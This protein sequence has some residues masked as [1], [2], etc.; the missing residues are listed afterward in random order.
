MN[1]YKEALGGEII[2]I[3]RYGVAPMP[4]DEDYK[5]KIMHARLTFSDN[6]IMVSDSFMGHQLAKGDNIEL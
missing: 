1:F 4:C 6:M 5:Q 2:S 3:Q